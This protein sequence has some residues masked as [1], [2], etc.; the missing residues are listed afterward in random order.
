MQVGTGL[1]DTFNVAPCGTVVA[2]RL[3]LGQT[4]PVSTTQRLNAYSWTE[5]GS[6]CS[7]RQGSF[8]QNAR[9]TTP[10]PSIIGF[11]NGVAVFSDTPINLTAAAV[12]QNSDSITWFGRVGASPANANIAVRRMRHVLWSNWTG[13]I[14]SMRHFTPDCT[15]VAGARGVVDVFEPYAVEN[16]SFS[17]ATV[18]NYHYRP[19]KCRSGGTSSRTNACF[20]SEERTGATNNAWAWMA[21]NNPNDGCSLMA[22]TAFDTKWSRCRAGAWCPGTGQDIYTDAGFLCSGTGCSGLS[23]ASV[24]VYD[25]A[26]Q[27][28]STV[29]CTGATCTKSGK[30]LDIVVTPSIDQTAISVASAG[31]GICGATPTRTAPSRW[32]GAVIQFTTGAGP[33]VGGAGTDVFTVTRASGCPNNAVCSLTS[34]SEV[35]QRLVWTNALST[36]SMTARIPSGINP[37]AAFSPSTQYTYIVMC[38]CL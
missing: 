16:P 35:S 27:V 15:P 1:D 31:T 25:A 9:V 20:Y 32:G 30:N 24:G 6:G 38:S 19:F 8:A 10:T 37:G 13:Y 3:W 21:C 18:E 36:T 28:L 17:P 7:I 11:S 22:G 4:G 34:A 12:L 5:C 29:S 23:S 26:V 2:E 33:C 14:A